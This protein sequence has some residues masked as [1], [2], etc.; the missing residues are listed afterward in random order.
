MGNPLF[1]SMGMETNKGFLREN[2]KNFKIVQNSGAYFPAFA[3]CI[4]EKIGYHIPWAT[5]HNCI[6]GVLRKISAST[7]L[8]NLEIH[9]GFLRFSVLF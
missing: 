7:A 3:S 9:K 4:F 6:F 5:P 2:L 1:V 8:S